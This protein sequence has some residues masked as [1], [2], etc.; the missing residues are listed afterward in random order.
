MVIPERKL[1]GNLLYKLLGILNSIQNKM[2]FD[3]FRL[4]GQFRDIFKFIYYIKV[5]I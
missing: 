3:F 5:I 4:Y 2:R 1:Y